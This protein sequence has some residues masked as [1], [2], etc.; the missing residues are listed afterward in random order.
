MTI[1]DLQRALFYILECTILR[2]HIAKA[3]L[4]HAK[5]GAQTGG[6]ARKERDRIAAHAPSVSRLVVPISAL[7]MT[8]DTTSVFVEVADWAFER[9]TVEIAN[10]EGATSVIK[11]GVEPGERVVVR[12]GVRLND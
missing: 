3:S 5:S 6:R 11:S 8:N 7:L 1:D 2:W 4:Q 10:Q 9:R 12:G